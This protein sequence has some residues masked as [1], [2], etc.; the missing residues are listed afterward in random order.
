M[1]KY[2]YL[3]TIAAFLSSC[4][5]QPKEDALEKLDKK[6]AREVTLTTIVQ[7]DSV[8]H[9]T[10]QNIWFNGEQIAAKVDT[11]I[12]PLKTNTWADTTGVAPLNR[13]PIYV[14]V[15]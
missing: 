3:L 11:L 6:S 9:L 4:E 15:Q 13:V 14:T 12:T 8:L 10:K 7:G 1:Y 5:S 2:L